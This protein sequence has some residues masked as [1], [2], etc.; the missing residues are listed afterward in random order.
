MV[1]G[2]GSRMAARGSSG[3]GCRASM[4]SSESVLCVCARGKGGWEVQRTVKTLTAS[5]SGGGGNARRLLSDC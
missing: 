1:G 3:G 4:R 5:G 2:V